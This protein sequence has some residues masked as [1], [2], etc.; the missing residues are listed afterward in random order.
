MTYA[1]LGAP[2]TSRPSRSFPEPKDLERFLAGSLKIDGREMTTALEAVSRNGS[3]CIYEVW[4]SEEEIQENG[5]DPAS[6][7]SY[8]PGGI[9]S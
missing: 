5:L 6:S 8:S 4:L 1:P 9:V 2:L 7:L 3:Y